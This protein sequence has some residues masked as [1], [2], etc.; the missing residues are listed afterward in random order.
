MGLLCR[1]S[2]LTAIACGVVG[3]QSARLWYV[4]P[5]GAIVISAYIIYS[6]GLICMNQVDKIVGKGAPTEFIQ[7]LEE[8]ANSHHEQLEVDVLRAYYFGSKFI[9]EV[10][11]AS[12]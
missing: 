11:C 2:N 8:L 7:K 6:W 1:L 12:S 4:D 10:R 5:W 9:C 3:T